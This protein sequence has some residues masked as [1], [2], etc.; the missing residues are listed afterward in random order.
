[1]ERLS[2]ASALSIQQWTQEGRGAEGSA[3]QELHGGHRPLLLL[4]P[5][6]CGG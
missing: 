5:W 2:P 6:L 3:G 1:M 4:D